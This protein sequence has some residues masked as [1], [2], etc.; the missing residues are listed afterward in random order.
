MRLVA[1]RHGGKGLSYKSC[2]PVTARV[3]EQEPLVHL[4]SMSIHSYAYITTPYA[5]RHKGVM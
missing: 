2:V 5:R 4:A 1:K 3:A